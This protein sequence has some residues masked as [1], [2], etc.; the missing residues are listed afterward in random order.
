[1]V[2]GRWREEERGQCQKVKKK[3]E[4]ESVGVKKKP[5][6]RPSPF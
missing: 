2:A 6:G 4:I 5:L 3:G 1:M